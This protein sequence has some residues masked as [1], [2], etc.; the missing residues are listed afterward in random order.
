PMQK[1]VKAL[2]ERREL[3][4]SGIITGA[5]RKRASIVRN[6]ETTDKMR[7]TLSALQ[8]LQDSQL[9]AIQQKLAQAGIRKKE[10]A[11][12]VIFARM[13]LP[14]V[15]GGTAAIMIYMVNYFPE[16]GSFKRFMCLAA[17]LGL[18]YKGADLYINNLI[19]K[20]THA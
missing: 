14:I 19:T 5:A 17:A 6:T 2:N 20:R 16:W 3:L 1:R 15:L 4:K 9:K 13:V 18:S 11:V 7:D 12:A 10:W 8:V